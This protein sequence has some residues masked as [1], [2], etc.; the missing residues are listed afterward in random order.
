MSKCVILVKLLILVNI[1]LVFT[2][3]EKLTFVFIIFVHVNTVLQL[4]RN[5]VAAILAHF[6]YFE[7]Y[8]FVCCDTVEDQLIHHVYFISR[9][10]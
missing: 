3:V 2:I 10:L 9:L 8:N 1:V 4:T 5:S 7:Y 6:L